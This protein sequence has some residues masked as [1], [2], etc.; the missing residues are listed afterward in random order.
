MEEEG[1]AILSMFPPVALGF[2]YGSGA[3]QQVGYEKLSSRDS[4]GLPMLDAIFAV[5]HPEDWHDKNLLKNPGHYSILART[6]GA[7]RVANIQQN[8]GARL[9]YNTMVP[10]TAGPHAGRLMKYGVIGTSDLL[11]DLL[12]WNWLYAA[13]RMHKPIRILHHTGKFLIKEESSRRIL[14]HELGVAIASN[15]ES[16]VRVSLLQ[17]PGD[18]SEEEL[19]MTI[20][21]LSYGGDIRM[22]FGEN[23]A[24]VR[25]IVHGSFHLFHNL[26]EDVCRKIPQ[27]ARK[28][29]SVTFTQ[30]QSPGALIEH[31]QNLPVTLQRGL[32]KYTQPGDTLTSACTSPE[33]SR[34]LRH[35]V[36]NSSRGQAL[37]GVVTAGVWKAMTYAAAKVGKRFA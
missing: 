26:Y 28:G 33:I 30:D 8:Y 29:S 18:F 27:M 10:I 23:P 24:K 32:S 4:R 6:M 20:A 1:S 12:G 15:L 9:Y 21:G 16:A 7:E 22:G 35:I 19:Y 5:D 31:A 2:T 13:G 11:D 25:N 17:L 14:P 37:K 36:R 34:A 3:F